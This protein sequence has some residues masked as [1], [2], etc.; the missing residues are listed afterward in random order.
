[1][2]FLRNYN[3][4]KR[5]MNSLVLITKAEKEAMRE[6]FPHLDIVRT[7]RQR[8]SRGRYYMEEAPQAMKYLRAVRNRNVVERHGR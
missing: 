7:M 6:K 2:F 4:K 5:M 1:M 3:L 8:S